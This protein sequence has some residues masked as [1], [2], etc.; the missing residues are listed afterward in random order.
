M[1]TLV[2]PG[3]RA[4]GIT[5]RY[6]PSAA[7]VVPALKRSTRTV[8]AFSGPPCALVT[9]PVTVAFSWASAGSGAVAPAINAAIQRILLMR[10]PP[11]LRRGEVAGRCTRESGTVPVP[12]VAPELVCPGRGSPP[13]VG[14]SRVE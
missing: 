4:P 5:S 2:L 11:G 12:L 7:V 8:T 1:V 10:F 13:G 3:R 14:A 9:R 6:V